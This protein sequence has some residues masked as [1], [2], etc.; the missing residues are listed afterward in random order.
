MG[1]GVKIL[2]GEKSMKNANSVE[3][4]PVLICA[5]VLKKLGKCFG[6]SKGPQLF[7]PTRDLSL[8]FFVC[9][10]GVLKARADVAPIDTGDDCG[11]WLLRQFPQSCGK[12]R[13]RR[14]F[15]RWGSCF[16]CMLESTAQDGKNGEGTVWKKEIAKGLKPDHS[17]FD[18]VFSL[19]APGLRIEKGAG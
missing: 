1:F 5:Q 7:F 17:K 6:G 4:K 2:T 19:K 13:F 15:G 11:V 9:G 16:Y 12:N 10:K 14:N 18:R 8:N 3:V